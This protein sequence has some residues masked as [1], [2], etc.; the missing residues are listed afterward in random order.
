MGSRA[1]SWTICMRARPP[2]ARMCA[3]VCE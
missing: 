2:T 3:C 1:P